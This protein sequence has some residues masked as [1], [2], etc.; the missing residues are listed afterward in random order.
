LINLSSNL[1]PRLVI[2]NLLL[3]LPLLKVA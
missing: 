3:S 2:E 1:N